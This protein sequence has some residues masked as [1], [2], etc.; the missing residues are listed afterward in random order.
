[1]KKSNLA[2]KKNLLFIIQSRA[3]IN[4]FSVYLIIK[5]I[6]YHYDLLAFFDKVAY[7][8]EQNI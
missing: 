2:E 1:M 8:V 5:L 7:V 3:G 4:N 6:T